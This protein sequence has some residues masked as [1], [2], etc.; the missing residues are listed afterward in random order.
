MKR[1]LAK[2]GVLALLLVAMLLP[3]TSAM[4]AE[5][6]QTGWTTLAPMSTQRY[7]FETG[8]VNGKIYAVGGGNSA[9][10]LSSVE[11]YDPTA[12]TWTTLASM[13]TPRYAF[14]TAVVDGKIYAIGGLDGST[15]RLSSVEVYD[16]FTNTWTTLAS[17]SKARSHFQTEVIEGKIYVIGNS[18][19]TEVYDPSTNTWTTLASMSTNRSKFQ[20]EVINGKIYAIGGTGGTGLSSVEVYDPST[21]TWTTLASM[22]SARSEFQTETIDG[23]I[24]AIGGNVDGFVASLSSSV[25]V[26]DPSTDTWATLASMSEPRFG[27]QST[28]I[29]GKIYA[30]GGNNGKNLTSLEV[31]DPSSDTWTTLSTMSI[32]RFLAKTEVLDGKIYAIG[33]RGLSSM[34]VYAATDNKASKQL[35]VVLEVNE[36]L[37][38]SI[39]NNLSQN[40]T[41]TWSSSDTSVASVDANGVVT[42]LAPGNTVITATDG[43]S[44]TESINVLVVQNADGQRLAVDL[45]VGDT[46]L[47]TVDDNA[48]T[49]DVTWTS[50]NTFVATV[51]TAGRVTAASAG[52]TLI[53]VT[54]A[55]TNQI[56]QVYVRV[57]A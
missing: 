27:F 43:G 49:A 51:S 38:L 54:D 26:Y 31:Y 55:D 42:A 35:K 15:P 6:G 41:V 32:G 57:R 30:F 9:A 17:M 45:K 25:E 47:L 12:N 44:F 28:L 48:N 10:P 33:G 2:V 5:E 29:D 40:T 18:A 22:S 53:T 3:N 8:V 16:P 37:Q 50:S 4:A 1:K 56:G 21:N 36:T 46:S 7:D 11:V 19:P 52:L 39:S 20:T 14:R 23:K 13:S 24:Y 34:E